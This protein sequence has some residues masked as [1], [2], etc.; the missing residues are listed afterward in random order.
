M[1]ETPP[2]SKPPGME[3]IVIAPP[4]FTS[5]AVL[6]VTDTHIVL[7]RKPFFGAQK[8]WLQLP[9]SQVTQLTPSEHPAGAFVQLDNGK[10]YTVG[11]SRKAN[12]A[13]LRDLLERALSATGAVAVD[14]RTG[15]AV[16]A[17]A[18]AS[19]PSA[20]VVAQPRASVARACPV[21][22]RPMIVRTKGGGSLGIIAGVIVML[23]GN[24]MIRDTLSGP[25]AAVAYLLMIPLLFVTAFAVN[26]PLRVS[27]C[28]ACGKDVP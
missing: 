1:A 21:C 20:P 8:V 23:V 27:R 24:S 13:V 19:V 26:Y 10:T 15:R 18:A 14:A 11:A 17:A 2:L 16:V 9:L 5:R 22:G 25:P 28:A 12:A 6:R 4:G 3:V 7:E